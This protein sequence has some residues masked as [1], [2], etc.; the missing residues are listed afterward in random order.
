MNESELKPCP[1]CGCRATLMLNRSDKFNLTDREVIETGESYWVKC[2]NCQVS[3]W[4][5]KNIDGAMTQWNKRT[6]DAG[7][8]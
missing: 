4:V 8:E 6:T 2:Q 7:T 5:A 1:F 3:T